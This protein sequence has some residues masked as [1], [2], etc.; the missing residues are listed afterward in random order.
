MR[1]C[2]IPPEAVYEPLGWDPTPEIKRKHYRKYFTEELEKTKEI[3][4]IE[5]PFDSFNIKR[6]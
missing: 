5:T 6:G 4:P 2:N 1:E 3:M